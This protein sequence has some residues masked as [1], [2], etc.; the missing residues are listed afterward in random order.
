MSG[1]CAGTSICADG[2]SS[3]PLAKYRSDSNTEREADE[4]IEVQDVNETVEEPVDIS[5]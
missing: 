3:I 5:R 1:G 2:P 4:A